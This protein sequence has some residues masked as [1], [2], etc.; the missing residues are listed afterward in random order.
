MLLADQAK[1][2]EAAAKAAAEKEGKAKAA[3][4]AKAGGRRAAVPPS[5]MFAAEHDALFGREQGQYGALDA[6]GVPT[7]DGAG[8]PLSKSAIKKLKKMLDKQKK[9]HE[10]VKA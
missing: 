7:A 10:K 4:E 5:Q 1:K 6:D 9:L 2:R 3:A 8:E